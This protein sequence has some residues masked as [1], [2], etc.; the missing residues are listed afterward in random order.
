MTSLHQRLQHLE[1]ERG[2]ARRPGEGHA[3]LDLFRIAGAALIEG[4]KGAGMS[5]R[6][7]ALHQR[8]SDGTATDADLEFIASLP[9]CEMTPQELVAHFVRVQEMY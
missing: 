9:R 6:L 4:M 8:L 5:E 7:A 3:E 2:A 1:R